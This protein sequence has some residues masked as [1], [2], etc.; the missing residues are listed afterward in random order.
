M[1]IERARSDMLGFGQFRFRKFL[2]LDLIAKCFGRPSVLSIPPWQFNETYHVSWDLLAIDT[3][4]RGYAGGSPPWAD[5][6]RRLTKS[7]RLLPVGP[8]DSFSAVASVRTA[9][10]AKTH[11]RRSWSLGER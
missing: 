9:V 3:L 11:Q 2:G 1:R 5:L 10:R 4:A 6:N 8:Q 7:F